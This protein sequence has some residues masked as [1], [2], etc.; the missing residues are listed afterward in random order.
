METDFKNDDIYEVLVSRTDADIIS[1]PF[2]KN[3]HCDFGWNLGPSFWHRNKTLK[4]AMETSWISPPKKFKAIFQ[5]QSHVIHVLGLWRC[6]HDHLPVTV[7]G[8]Y[9]NELRQLREEIQKE[10]SGKL[11]RGKWLLRDLDTAHSSQVAAHAASDTGFRILPHPASSPDLILSVFYL[12]PILKAELRGK[13][14]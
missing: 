12:F 13:N 4:D 14:F 10:H 11:Q 6:Y 9:S 3:A 7:S 5:W 8:D 1:R 2:F